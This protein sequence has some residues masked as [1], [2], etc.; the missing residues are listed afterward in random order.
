MIWSFGLLEVVTKPLGVYI[1]KGEIKM[2]FLDTTSCLLTSIVI[3]LGTFLVCSSLK[4]D[5]KI[6]GLALLFDIYIFLRMIGVI[7]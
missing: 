6:T 4:D 2:N 5:K 1:L 3:W 7:A